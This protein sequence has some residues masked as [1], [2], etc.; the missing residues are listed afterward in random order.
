MQHIVQQSFRFRTDTS[1]HCGIERLESRRLL[2]A[3]YT[4]VPGIN[5]LA[6]DASRD[7]LYA[8]TDGGEVVR[9]DVQSGQ[10]LTP[11]SE[12]G[13]LLGLDIT[14]DDGSIFVANGDERLYHRMDLE[15]GATIDIGYTPSSIES[16][17]Y[18]V[19]ISDGVVFT[20]SQFAG[21]GWVPLREIDL[22]TNQI[23]VS[24]RGLSSVR[25]NSGLSR[26]A[27]YSAAGLSESNISSG[28]LHL[29]NAAANDWDASISTGQFLSSRLHE[30]SRDGEYFAMPVGSGLSIFD[31][32]LGGVTSLTSPGQS[33]GGFAFDPQINRLYVTFGN[34]LAAFDTLTWQEKYRVPIGRTIN[35]SARFD[36]GE[37]VVGDGRVFVSD[38][39]G[40][41]SVEL[42]VSD[43]QAASFVVEGN[44][45]FIRT[46]VEDKFRVSVFDAAGEP[47]INFAG[48]V[49]FA[50]TDP[51]ADLPLPYT[52]DGDDNGTAEF[53]VSFQTP[54]THAISLLDENSNVVATV[55]GISVHVPGDVS[56]LPID[57]RNGLAFDAQR[58]RLYVSTN[59]GV[60]K[61]YD[62]ATETLLEPLELG[63]RLLGLDVT[64]DGNY[65]VTGEADYVG[66]SGLFY[67]VDLDQLDVLETTGGDI[68]QSFDEISYTYDFGEGGIW[69][70]AATADGKVLA[71]GEYRG[72]GWVPVREIDP[73]TGSFQI[74]DIGSG[75]GEVRQ[76]TGMSRSADGTLIAFSE[77]NI[78][79]G[80]I[81][82]YD[83]VV[84]ELVGSVNT[85]TFLSSV[86]TAV[87]RNG[88]YVAAELGGGIRV[89]DREMNVITNLPGRDAGLAFD[90]A[91]DLLYV[92]EGGTIFAYETATW[93]VV[94]S[95]S[96]GESFSSS[97]QFD[98]G[99]ME[100]ARDGGLIFI[101]TP[102]GVRQVTFSTRAIAPDAVVQEGG[103]ATLIGNAVVAPGLAVSEYAWDLD[104][105]GTGFDTDVV[106]SSAI[107][108]AENID[109]PA[110]R[111]VALRVTD[112]AGS[113]S[114]AEA[115]VD[116]IN[117]APV[118]SVTGP[119]NVGHFETYTLALSSTDVADDTP[120]NWTI[121]WGDGSIDTLPGNA[122]S[123]THTYQSEEAFQITA[124][125]TDEDGTY[126][127]EGPSVLVATAPTIVRSSFNFDALPHRVEIAFSES[128]AD[129]VD[130]GDVTIRNLDFNL[131][132]STNDIELIYDETTQTASFGFIGGINAGGELTPLPDGNYSVSLAAG[133]VEDAVGNLLQEDLSFGFFVLAGDLDRDRDVDL[134]DAIDLVRNFGRTDD[135]LFSEG[136][137]DYD[138][139]VDLFD[140]LILQRNFGSTLPDGTERRGGVPLVS[141]FAKEEPRIDD[142]SE[143]DDD[144]LPH[145]KI[146]LFDFS[147]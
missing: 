102:T 86:L 40:F 5:D 143:A 122:T 146:T 121:D 35:G 147:R 116:I 16:D 75:F 129:S 11:F 53:S 48:T 77:S 28:P 12:P 9:Y 108:S 93:T 128:V 6:Y 44:S 105:D 49:S 29:Y 84:D 89:F 31:D 30:M 59:R 127:T 85:G 136:D 82:T 22:A 104:Y 43:G 57:D 139:D 96:L 133:S 26:S 112:A 118:L 78:S 99:M 68:E 65:L 33:L 60:V 94:D 24:S 72:S 109:G 1:A 71:D 126:A 100:V 7:R 92:H 125:L 17:A 91:A 124:S 10:V 62:L 138:G 18:D 80:P 67:T 120:V 47:A 66:G 70:F 34:E 87:S 130:V 131:V 45:R 107:F 41:V 52:F 69:D 97:L 145:F 137:L 140:A 36:R 8:T 81:F 20:T 114:I 15:T 88:A 115:T 55:G 13:Q 79:S 21:S 134:F 135:P 19:A 46:G 95:V 61:R 144:G 64:L 98:D 101:N 27:D 39:N 83:P 54:G 56:L 4:A 50:S 90:P 74:L 42:P 76:R 37:M 110:T 73:V 32:Q 25:Q 14:P 141:L 51:N 113:V 3:T 2:S 38:G 58:Q 119:A 117:V 142:L 63:A 132:V 23:T 111:T 103:S 123:A 106:G